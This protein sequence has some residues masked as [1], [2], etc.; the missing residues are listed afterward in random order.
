LPASTM[1]GIGCAFCHQAHGPVQPGN[2]ASGSYEGNPFWTSTRTGERFSMRPED[3][4]GLFGIAN[5]G[6]LLDP[7]ELLTTSTTTAIAGGVHA[8]PSVDSQAYLRS[9][10]F[11]GACHDVRLFGSD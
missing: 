8:R 1:E 11:C 9:S 4:E 7:R 6:Y 2:A 10:E 5:S 3:R